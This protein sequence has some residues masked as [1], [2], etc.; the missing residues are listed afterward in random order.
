[1]E[2]IE[3]IILVKADPLTFFFSPKPLYQLITRTVSQAKRLF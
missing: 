3:E 1:M 2:I